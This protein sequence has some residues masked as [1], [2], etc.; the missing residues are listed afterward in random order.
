MFSLDLPLRLIACFKFAWC[1]YLFQSFLSQQKKISIFK[2]KC[3]FVSSPPAHGR[4]QVG[5]VQ[6]GL[7]LPSVCLFADFVVTSRKQT[8]AQQG[9]PAINQPERRSAQLRLG[10]RHVLAAIQQE[11]H[12]P[13]EC[14]GGQE[15]QTPRLTREAEDRWQRLRFGK[16][17]DQL[18]LPVQILQGGRIS[19]HRFQQ[20]VTLCLL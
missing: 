7:K 9:V 16:L 1:L 8:F 19:C 15:E 5:F 11:R 13:S 6:L 14:H 2:G 4:W 20:K 17:C 3:A 12:F 18:R 10:K